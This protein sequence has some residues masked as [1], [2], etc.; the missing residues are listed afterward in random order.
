MEIIQLDK[1][2]T[3]TMFLEMKIQ[4]GSRFSNTRYSALKTDKKKSKFRIMMDFN[5]FVYNV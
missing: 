3:P 5:E 4:S 1:A 2:H